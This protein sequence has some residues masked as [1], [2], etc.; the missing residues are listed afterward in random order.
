MLQKVGD[1]SNMLLL[2]LRGVCDID[3]MVGPV[4]T[5]C[6]FDFFCLCFFLLRLFLF[7]ALSVA[8]TPVSLSQEASANSLF[9]VALLK[10]SHLYDAL[11]CSSEGSEQK[12]SRIVT[13]VTD[14][15]NVNP[16]GFGE[17]SGM[18]NNATIPT[19]S[20]PIAQFCCNAMEGSSVRSFFIEIWHNKE[21]VTPQSP[22]LLSP[23]TET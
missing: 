18:S 17:G 7:G 6:A 1:T 4:S 15:H 9:A 23:D 20:S 16:I 3:F 21:P 13:S 10:A 8:A 5:Q 19:D 12:I 22:D 11:L 2:L 14:P